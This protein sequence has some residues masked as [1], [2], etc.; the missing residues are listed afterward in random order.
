M[1][2]QMNSIDEMG[3]TFHGRKQLHSYAQKDAR[4][5]PPN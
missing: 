5:E 4:G 3:V 1:K 2:N